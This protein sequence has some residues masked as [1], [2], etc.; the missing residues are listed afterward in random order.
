MHFDRDLGNAKTKCNGKAMVSGTKHPNL[1]VGPDRAANVELPIPFD[2]VIGKHSAMFVTQMPSAED[3]VPLDGVDQ[4]DNIIEI[5][6]DC[7]SCPART[8]KPAFRKRYEP[9]TAIVG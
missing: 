6:I 9:T 3:T 5:C 4:A 7:G 1:A 8:S 2:G